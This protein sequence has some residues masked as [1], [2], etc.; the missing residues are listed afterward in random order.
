MPQATVGDI[1]IHY[2]VRGEG[3]PLVLINGYGGNSRAWF[4]EIPHLLPG[5]QSGHLRQSGDG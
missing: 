4:L 1:S 2:D 3:E 5:V